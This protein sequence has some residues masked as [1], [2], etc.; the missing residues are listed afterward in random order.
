M[1]Q[2]AGDQTHVAF[3]IWGER[4]DFRQKGMQSVRIQRESDKMI[5]TRL[6][7]ASSTV[8]IKSSYQ[9]SASPMTIKLHHDDP[10]PGGRIELLI[11]AFAVEYSENKNDSPKTTTGNSHYL[12]IHREMDWE[13]ARRHCESLDGHLPLVTSQEENDF[14]RDML[15]RET[16]GGD[17][18]EAIWL[19]ASDARQEGNWKWIDGS[20]VTFN[21]WGPK[22]PNNK[23]QIEHYAVLWRGGKNPNAAGDWSDQPLKSIQH[24][25][26]CVCEWDNP[27]A[28]VPLDATQ[29]KRKIDAGIRNTLTPSERQSGWKLLFDGKTTRGWRNYQATT[30]S[31]GWKVIEGALTQIDKGA[32]DIVTADQYDSFELSLEYKVAKGAKSGLLY[33]VL[34]SDGD[35]PWQSG[36]EVQIQDNINNSDRFKAGWL[37]HL[38]STDFDTTRPAGEWNEL[39]IRITPELCEHSVNGVKYFSYVKGGTA[40]NNRVANSKFARFRDFGE[41]K[42]GHIALLDQGG[43]V[44]FRNVKIRRL[45]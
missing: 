10:S 23:Q 7:G 45:L 13:S 40:W 36:P 15:M 24:R 2:N 3:S 6:G 4:V 16:A 39:R 31:S 11:R 21:A 14:L 38:Y 8:F 22:Q 34:E 18:K 30:I 32:G 37:C 28:I 20:P 17:G 41:A 25:V 35:A 26:F 44:S 19:G 9:D 42:R 12:F 43:Q 1:T 33:H 29:V 27:P 5:I